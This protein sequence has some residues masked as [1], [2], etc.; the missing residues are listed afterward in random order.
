[1]SSTSVR[2]IRTIFWTE[3]L[4]DGPRVQITDTRIT[5][6]S[7]AFNSLVPKAVAEEVDIPG[8][9]PVT[10]NL[11]TLSFSR[12]NGA[13][14]LQA[15]N[16]EGRVFIEYLGNL[17][18]GNSVYESIGT[19]VVEI[20]RVPDIYYTSVNLGK[21]IVSHDNDGLLSAQP[22]ISQNHAVTYYSTLP[23]PDSSLA[24]Y[25]ERETSPANDPDN[26][27][28]LTVDAFNKVIFYWLEE[29][30]LDIRWPK[31][32]D[33]YWLRW[34]PALSDYAH[35]TVDAA[36]STPQTGIAFDGP[37][38]EIVFQDDG[39][40]T[41]ARIDA[42]TQRLYVT[43]N[44][45]AD[46][47]NRSLL[48][49]SSN[50]TVW[51]VN[52]YSQAEG[53]QEVRSATSTTSGAVTTL[54]L[55]GT[56]G[57]EAG[58]VVT[59]GGISGFAL[60]TRIINST[61]L[62]I[63]QVIPNATSSLAF[64]V[65]ADDAA[66]L[67]A[68]ALVG[69]RINA[70][71]GHEVAGFIAGGTCYYPAGY[72]NPFTVGVTAANLGAIIPVNALPSDNL[73]TVRWFKKVPAPAAGFTDF[74]VPGK[75]GRYTVEYPRQIVSEAASMASDRY[76]TS[77]TL[78]NDGRV[79]LAAGRTAASASGLTTTTLYTPS[80]DSWPAGNAIIDSRAN[81]TATRLQDDRVLIVGGNGGASANT[82]RATGQLF[83]PTT[84]NWSST[85]AA[86]GA[87]SFHTATL[88]NDGRVLIAGGRSASSTYVNTA[89][90]CDPVGDP[91]LTTW[92][93]TPNMP[94]ARSSHAATKLLDGR[95]LITG[96]QSSASTYL[97]T[98][99]LF[100]P[101]TNTWSTAASMA[102]TRTDH[103][104]IL[105]ADGKVLVC[106]GANAAEHSSAEL[107]N[108]VTNTWT[109]VGSMAAARRNHTAHLLPDG[110]VAVIGA[111][112][113][114]TD[115]TKRSIELYSPVHQKWSPIA[116]LAVG[117]VEHAATMLADGRIL[118]AGGN[119]AGTSVEIVDPSSWETDDSTIVIAQGVG[120]DDL[121]AWEADG[122]VY[123]Q[124]NPALPGYNPNEEHA[125]MIG[126]RAYAL[127]DDLNI[128]TVT[129]LIPDGGTYTSRP[130]VLVSYTDP[131][132]DRPAIH[133]Y[134]VVRSDH[135]HDLEYNATAGT[136]LVKPYPLPL[137]PLPL[138][139]TGAERTS[140][141]IEIVGADDPANGTVSDNEA[142]KSFTFKD[143]KGFTWVHRGAHNGGSGV[144]TMKL[145]YLSRAGFYIPGTG[146]PAVGTVLPF[147]RLA[148]RY[149]EP[150]NINEIDNNEADE[151]QPVIY[152]PTW[153]AAAAELR[154]GETL[155]L[156]KFGL[157]QV[158]G[159][160]SAEVLYQQSI[161]QAATASLLNK[162]SVTLHDPTREKT[163][164]LDDSSVALTALPASLLTSVHLGKTY[165]QGLP[166]HLQQR[167]FFDPL[168]GAAGSLVFLGQF[169]DAPTGDDYL[170]LN[171]L[172]DAE[173]TLIKGMVPDNDANKSKWNAA[174]DALNTRVETFK[175]NPAQFGSYIVDTSKN[176]D[177]GE[178][179][180]VTISESD[181]AVDSYAIT[182][183]G[184]G[185]GYVTMVFGNGRA[186]TP[187]GDPVQVQ[188]FKV[189]NQ[190][191]VGDL[192]VIS[193]ANPLD[194]QVTLRHTGDFAAKP[195]D[196]E[197]DWRWATGA[198]S[199]PATYATTLTTRL[200]DSVSSTH[201]WVVLSDPGA[202]IATDSQISAAGPALPFPRALNVRPVTYVLDAQG[203][204]TSTVI[205][206]TSH[207][208]AERAEGYPG[209]FLRSST[210]VDFTGGV[211]GTIVFS[212]TLGDLDGFV[213]YV[214][215]VPAL[216]HN[217]PQPRFTLTNASSGL[218]PAGLE[219]QF[220][221]PPGFFT[222]GVNLIEVAVYTDADPNAVSAL[223]FRLEAAVETD[224]VTSGTTWQTP[225]DPTGINTNT[226]IIGGAPTNPFGGP[227]F[228]IN[229][230]WF[231]MR[232]RPKA[233]AEN[234]LGT[235]WSRW[236]PPQFV[237]G[238]VK[239]VL[240]AINPFEQRVKD[241]FNNSVNTDVSVIT[242]AGA[243]WEGN[244]ALTLSNI[245]DVGLIEIYETVLNRAR[246]ISID[247]NTNDPDTNNALLLAAGY[248][249]DL[250][251][252]L[253]N[254]AYADAANP[255]ISLDDQTTVT[256]V[257]TSR[258]SF[259]GQVASSLDE[260]LALLRGRDD[261]VSPGVSLAPAYNRLYW[262]YTRG[263]NS[264]EVL[265]AV[266]YNI[267]EKVGSSTADGVVDESD[268][269][270]M[271]PQG[272]GDA[273]GHYLTA[274]TGYYR[275][276]TNDNF[277]WSPRAE[278]VTVL[279]QPVTVDFQDERK[280]AAAAANTAR[281]AQ[282]VI[283]LT[284]RKSYRDDP[285]EGW[286]HF[287]DSKGTNTST[288]ETSRQ[289]LDEW[290]SRAT[291]GAYLH[292][293]VA[294]ALVPDED[295]YH[296]GVQKIDR[297]TIPELAELPAAAESFQT[298]ID[299]AS[300]HLNPL[301]LSPGTIAFDISPTELK[302]GT[303]HFEQVYGRALR[304]LVNASGAFNQAAVMTRSLR[305]QQNQID[306]YTTTIARQEVAYTNQ[307][308]DIFGRPYSGDIGVG[309]LYAQGY[310]GPDLIHW[311]IADRP[312][313]L[314]NTTPARTITILR[315]SSLGDVT[316]DLQ[317]S[318]F[319][320][321]TVTV[322]PSQ[323]VQYNDVWV[324]G[325][326]GSR[327]V[328]GELQ[329]ALQDA[330]QSYLALTGAFTRYQVAHYRA[331]NYKQVVE[332]RLDALNAKHS[333]Q[334]DAAEALMT[335]KRNMNEYLSA[336]GKANGLAEASKGA[337]D[338]LTES[339][340]KVVGVSYDATSPI[341]GAAKAVAV[342][343]QIVS[344]LVAASYLGK[345]RE[346]ELKM[347]EIQNDL[348]YQMLL[349]D[350]DYESAQ[351]YYDLR[352]MTLEAI[353]H[354]ETL[355]QLSITHQR[356]LQK[357]QNVLA[358]G[359]R[360]LAER[361]IFRQRAAAII[362]GYRTKDLSF[363]IFRNEALEQYRSLF[364][365]A[366]RYT[367]LAAKSYDYETGL[368]GTSTG[369][370]V[371]SAIVASRSLGDLTGGVPQSTT[372][373]LGDAGLAGSMARLSA[374]FSVAEGRLGINNPDQNGTLFSLRHE[375][376]RI[377]DD[378]SQTDDDAAWQQTL[379]QHIVSNLMNDPDAATLCRNLKKTD[380]SAVPGILIPFSSAIAQG[381]NWFGLPTAGGDHGYSTS[382]YS[383]KI[384]SAGM[385][386]KGYV[387]MDPYAFGTPN[388]GG[389]A[390]SGADV[391]SAT[392]YIYLIPTGTDHMFA[393]PLGD[394]GEVRTWQVHDQ[395][396]PLPYNLGASDFNSVQFF[397]ANGTL[398][399]QPWINRKHQAFR[400][401]ND[402][403]F[404]YSTMPAE[405]T[406]SRLV[407][408]S[409]WNSGWK[410]VIPAFTLLN[411]EQEGLNRFVRS[412]KDIQIFLR[413][414]SHSGN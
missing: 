347:I 401:V 317:N 133:A 393:P 6:V 68:T 86:P 398:S 263:I 94:T 75:V 307:L 190:L 267:K 61:Q 290:V 108:P 98:C 226:A 222:A 362:Q 284:Y 251:T 192:K 358:K 19:D 137:M 210:G 312:N 223:N 3:G 249:N 123:V 101:G 196:Y 129:E 390:T 260:E 28:P 287:R 141:D 232:Y 183:T 321:R 238:W 20:K 1:V 181:T 221:L 89:I 364:D 243:R 389:P 395:A 80:S 240:A 124:N 241:L 114:A 374:D 122:S 325:G 119:G 166:P 50:E 227:Q 300:A 376:F 254:E 265:Y 109:A 335:A 377:L 87:R 318:Q 162:N 43:F 313:D 259:E 116:S 230:R 37:P 301:G 62:E 233:S 407:G 54:T 79:L 146:E 138:V 351:M 147:L 309:K 153:P 189:A 333:H 171:V 46:T 74:Y 92:T 2:P 403:A 145:Y 303:S 73:L 66:P 11:T 213:L 136:M 93:A 164:A 264:G 41:E 322:A 354:S 7:P 305:N 247:A 384:Y 209:L 402:P 10:P 44:A 158:R 319:I 151:P 161:A 35:Y 175:P 69:A 103:A 225:S 188:V 9:T 350:Y 184:Q 365:L 102:S 388:A 353:T 52:L 132:D 283:A 198:A 36:G 370:G 113:S 257:N 127:R 274:L 324:S 96:G 77:A 334:L 206:T 340:P 291:Q 167:F 105:L 270:R 76:Q 84:G 323:F 244:I 42:A 311:Y 115:A 112:A 159:Q 248:L 320:S 85:A 194:E 341:R 255:T 371:F 186:F 60:I 90:T 4:F 156:P 229:D 366:S 83:D 386:L 218:S 316:A 348:T 104:A 22:V 208:D 413:T 275:L 63:S 173:V 143:R 39:T 331:W 125:F 220:S 330:Q 204:P 49:F 375:L 239:R 329:E 182:A 296:S 234:V 107:Y 289:G 326:L 216:A 266:N 207:T 47:R 212:A 285:S 294:N 110:R 157:P 121:P 397:N 288:A 256:E 23:R 278:A 56:A 343:T 45:G 252:L 40:L 201:Q 117:R 97:S 336:S 174:I 106:G 155:T 400:A 32:Q 144:L 55:A 299:N 250:Y 111:S 16:V 277:T 8:Y 170:D 142:Y 118:V 169:T 245:N 406:S 383:T 342:A 412:V 219:K 282:Q 195:E 242:Q 34:S 130:F 369:Q 88:L 18:Q 163:V 148:G 332:Q 81:H 293:A 149:G 91:T 392:P 271:F 193:S 160:I 65:Q 368:L 178:D 308:I 211:P 197:F 297:T 327:T 150:L 404:F 51:Y 217:A 126:G 355:M 191:Y 339:F 372:S 131:T 292:W 235:P 346:E 203:Q 53:R 373:T 176:R 38:P 172:T 246:S 120:T 381:H 258:F 168:R 25:A 262:N 31:H 70:P 391:L 214:N 253:G 15:Y 281:S 306:D 154:V 17:R 414:Y 359:D 205:T 128:P 224:L 279:G 48:K 12:F 180:L 237:E 179:A 280:L 361:E 349:R 24:Y 378:D 310:T 337:A 99:I 367:Y 276:L 345:S 187:E 380:G 385:V 200:G 344:K 78:L 410:I 408:R 396:L 67:A 165:F 304:S 215:K 140:K 21:E 135:E 363:R 14:Q 338:A 328:T 100:D 394:T 405:F 272:H 134:K 139:G 202:I 295:T 399:E 379:E 236:M 357:V 387:G 231:T 314:V 261:F 71:A 268:A 29:G 273:Y 360:I 27:D 59:G 302:A 298:T 228:V 72:L 199:A 64:T 411:N 58:M 152:R 33:R 269:R 95:V 26:G 409:V 356:A 30:A 177:V 82:Y 352:M 382:S 185:T 315:P 13:G 5:T 57:L 286:G